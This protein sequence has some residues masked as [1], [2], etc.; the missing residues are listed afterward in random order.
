MKLPAIDVLRGL[1]ALGVAWFHSRVDLWVGYREINEHPDVFSA[2]DRGLSWL[3][4]PV[5][6]MGSLVMLFFVLSGFCIHLPLAGKETPVQLLPY[7]VRR[8]LRIY[9]AYL[10]TL[11]LCL[12]LAVAL[13]WYESGSRPD[14]TRYLCSTVLL[15]NWVF[16]GGQVA[17][18]P[19]LWS[20]PIEVE[21]YLVYPVLLWSYLRFGFYGSLALTLGCTSVGWLLFFQGSPLAQFTFFKFAIIWNS[22]AWLAERYAE[23]RLPR[24]RISHTFVLIT[25]LCGTP[26]IGLAGM[27]VFYVHYGWG[28]ASFLG[29]WW[30]ITDGEKYLPNQSRLVRLLSQLGTVSYSLYLI[31]FPLFRVAGGIWFE[32]FGSKP[33]SFLVPTVATLIV[34]PFAC[35]FYIVVEKPSHALARRLAHQIRLQGNTDL[36]SR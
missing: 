19:S 26:M 22:G 28:L 2:V 27:D 18:N 21:L 9:P 35:I 14:L 34:I 8:G 12:A 33:A 23:K 10:A 6:Q 25:V 32:L 24:W 36:V 3:S 15:Q 20:I 31:H 16:Q 13:A 1:A 11:V 5:S 29:L 4:L 17:I 7:G 30:L